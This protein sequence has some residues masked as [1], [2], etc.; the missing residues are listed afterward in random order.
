MSARPGPGRVCASESEELFTT[1]A[2]TM[3]AAITGTAAPA[4]GVN[5]SSVGDRC[6]D[7]EVGQV[8]DQ[9]GHRDRGERLER[10]QDSSEH[11][12]ASLADGEPTEQPH[13]A[14]EVAAALHV[15]P[16]LAT[17]SSSV[18]TRAGSPGQLLHRLGE[19]ARGAVTARQGPAAAP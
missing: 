3:A 14:T 9:V 7:E 15:G 6:V 13:R 17:S 4:D 11:E 8:L 19:F 16:I 5:P 12:G 1:V 2:A 10:E 18:V